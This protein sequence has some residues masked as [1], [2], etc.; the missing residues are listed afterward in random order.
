M[1]TRIDGSILEKKT[2]QT[3]KGGQKYMIRRLAENDIP[4]MRELFRSTVLC[5]N[6]RDYTDEECK[7]WASCGDSTEHWKRFLCGTRRRREYHRVFVDE[8]RR[9][10]AFAFRTQ[11]L[12]G[13][14]RGY[15]AAFGSRETGHGIRCG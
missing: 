5:V 2:L 8:R 4:Q 6:S 7:D 1:D 14:R 12:A 11:G 10:S 3:E 9:A 15:N 13:K